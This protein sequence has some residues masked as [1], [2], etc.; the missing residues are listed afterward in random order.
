MSQQQGSDIQ[1]VERAENVRWECVD[2]GELSSRNETQCNN[3]GSFQ[4]R[5]VTKDDL[6]QEVD[7]DDVEIEDSPHPISSVIAYGYA[8]FL[9]WMG[10]VAINATAIAA[11]TVFTGGGVLMMPVTRRNLG[12]A[13]DVDIPALLTAT[14]GVIAFLAGSILA[15]PYI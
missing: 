12:E 13:L 4:Y 15:D 8:I 1:R 6:D 9:F 7:V 14:V 10:G 5:R 3:C 2:C 11:A